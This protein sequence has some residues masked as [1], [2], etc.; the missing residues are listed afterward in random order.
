MHS[1]N[2]R[3]ALTCL[4]AMA[5]VIAFQTILSAQT[6]AGATQA[7]MIRGKQVYQDACLA[8]HQADGGGVPAMNPSLV[9]T[10][11]VLGEKAILVRIILQGMTGAQEVN[12]DTY[13]NVMAP[14]SD[15]TDQQIA[16]VL[17]YVRNSFGN[18][19]TPITATEV[20]AIRA[21]TQK[22]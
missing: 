2:M 4:L 17:T 20:K 22:P 3:F 15:L 7:S 21:K 6:K 14:K 19:A 10:K 18:N 16:D 13:R 12:G 1:K 5:T 11:W 8:C 9:K